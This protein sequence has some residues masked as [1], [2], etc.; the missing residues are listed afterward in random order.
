[1]SVYRLE[2]RDQNLRSIMGH[3]SFRLS[4]VDHLGKRGQLPDIQADPLGLP[5][6]VQTVG[7]ISFRHLSKL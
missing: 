3:Y 4:N 6:K 5:R 2:Q 1:M 7:G